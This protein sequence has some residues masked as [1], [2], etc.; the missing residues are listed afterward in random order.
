[1]IPSALAKVNRGHVV[2]EPFPHIVIPDVLPEDFYNHLSQTFPEKVVQVP[3]SQ[4]NTAWFALAEDAIDNEAMPIEWREF[5]RYH[6]SHDFFREILDLWGGCIKQSYPNLP[7]HF[8][9][10]IEEFS[11]GIRSKGRFDNPANQQQDIGMDCAIGVNSPV[12][13]VS[14]VRG[15]H[16]DTNYKLFNSVLYFRHPEDKTTG[17]DLELYRYKK[18][19]LSYPSDG[20]DRNVIDQMPFTTFHSVNLRHLVVDKTVS[21]APN[22]LVMWLNTPYSLHGVTPRSVTPFVRRY[23]SFFGECFCGG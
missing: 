9:K 23:V 1:M 13:K 11:S 19:R 22:T 17:G 12:K 4:N 5:V 3:D 18:K 7:S 20:I 8:G 15:P 6:C 14:S 16:I 2:T 10:P 21:Y